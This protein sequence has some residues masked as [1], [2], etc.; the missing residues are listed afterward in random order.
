M[1][2]RGPVRAR[3]AGL[4]GLA[5]LAL[6]L[7]HP[8]ADAALVFADPSHAGGREDVAGMAPW[9]GPLA[10]MDEHLPAGSVVLSDPATSYAI[11]MATRHWVATLVDQHSSP[12]D[13]LALARIL[14]ARDALDPNATWVTTRGVVAARG[15]TAIALNDRFREVPTLDYWA[16][17]HAWYRA[18]RARFDAE[19]GAFRRTFDSGDFVVYEIDTDSL[20]RLA[21]GGAR[22]PYVRPAAPGEPAPVAMGAG[23]PSLAGFRLDRAAASP[24]ET[25]SAV[26][27]WAAPG[28]LPAGSYTVAMRFDHAM[29]PD[30]RAPAW[31]AKP[32]RKAYEA[33]AG[34]RYRF[35]A[36]HLPVNGEYGVDR[37]A[38]N[39]RITDSATVV[40]PADVAP[41]EYEVQVRIIR[42]PHYPNYRLGDFLLDRDYYSGPAVGRLLVRP[43]PGG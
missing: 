19:P 27:T 4:A 23:L 12:N 43:R 2:A 32:A 17:G 38:P 41:G 14:Q 1:A 37:W 42:Q 26:C 11:P 34:V 40:V 20:A 5:G 8:V 7:R 10:W 31:I 30:F 22:R 3:L 6:L 28:P 29:P 39:E 15:V 9:S 36:D 35:R 25:L 18:A 16:P 33:R 21:D 24:G 13:S